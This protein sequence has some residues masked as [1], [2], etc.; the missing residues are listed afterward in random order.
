MGGESTGVTPTETG[1]GG[2]YHHGRVAKSAVAAATEL[3]REGGQDAL[4]V[5]SVASAI[6]V[7]H[8]ALYRHFE[9]R[10]ALLSAVAA[11][12][13]DEAVQRLT[14]ADGYADVI[15]AYVQWALESE[16]L[17]RC[18]FDRTGDSEMSTAALG[19]LRDVVAASYRND[20]GGSTAEVRD[21]VFASWGQVHGLVDL[22]WKRLLRATDDARA[23]T[24]IVGLVV[25]S[26]SA[27]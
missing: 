26:L 7:T 9:D 21:A 14:R 27:P 10:A 18:A 5:R 6:G 4:T 17:Y 12:W 22:Y 13:M 25:R 23:A 20:V 8:T 1:E 24:Y 16:H 15:E 19:R 2:A 3:V 11:L